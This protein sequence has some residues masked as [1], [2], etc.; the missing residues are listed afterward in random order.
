[1][2]RHFQY[3]NIYILDIYIIY[4]YLGDI[5]YISILSVSLSGLRI[6][7]SC[8]T[9]QIPLLDAAHISKD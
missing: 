2:I 4:K 7:G 3:I 6:S 8:R 5:Y 1:M 9:A